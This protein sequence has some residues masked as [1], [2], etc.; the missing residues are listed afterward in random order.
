MHR[1]HILLVKRG[2]HTPPLY[3]S[4]CGKHGFLPYCHATS[5]S[6]MWPS[7]P[8]ALTSSVLPQ[9]KYTQDNNSSCLSLPN[10]VEKE[11]F[12]TSW[13]LDWE[14][15][16]PGCPRRTEDMWWL[17]DTALSPVMRLV[18]LLTGNSSTAFSWILISLISPCI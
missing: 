3:L 14:P 10:P 8:R 4:S 16:H 18:L 7:A 9:V 6:L 12:R 15:Q 1:S 11:F 5:R 13:I 17:R 2:G